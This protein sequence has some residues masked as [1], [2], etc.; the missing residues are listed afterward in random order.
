[1][2]I[3]LWGTRQATFWTRAGF[4]Q[5]TS[6]YIKTNS[7]SG[8]GIVTSAT[9]EDKGYRVVI[10]LD[11]EDMLNS[12]SHSYDPGVFALDGFLTEEE[13]AKILESL[14][15]GYESELEIEDPPSD[16]FSLSDALRSALLP[17]PHAVKS[18]Q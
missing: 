18:I 6:V 4:V 9:P 5:E 17:A 15:D 10:Q 11:R 3:L 8:N 2:E 16:A 13:E 12:F 14:G 7:Y 1:M